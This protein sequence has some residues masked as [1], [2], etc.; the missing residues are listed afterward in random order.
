MGDN[1]ASRHRVSHRCL[2]EMLESLLDVELSNFSELPLNLLNSVSERLQEVADMNEREDSSYTESH[3]VSSTGSDSS[4]ACELCGYNAGICSCTEECS[5]SN[6]DFDIS[7]VP[8]PQQ[9][10]EQANQDDTDDFPIREI[11]SEE[12]LNREMDACIKN[13]KTL[14]IELFSP[15]LHKPCMKVTPLYE[16]FIKS[17]QE[18]LWVK[19]NIDIIGRELLDKWKSNKFVKFISHMGVEVLAECGPEIIIFNSSMAVGEFVEFISELNLEE[20][21]QQAFAL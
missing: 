6:E 4:S 10:R 2:T 8:L 16:R 14:I 20:D 5:K 9:S 17:H 13:N 21:M 15:L 18:L 11:K 3:A 19:I 1:M 7:S 12:E